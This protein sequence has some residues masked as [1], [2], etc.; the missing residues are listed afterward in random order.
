[1]ETCPRAPE[2]VKELGNH[3]TQFVNVSDEM[4]SMLGLS[5]KMVLVLNR[6]RYFYFSTFHC[7]TFLSG[8]LFQAII[9]L[10]RF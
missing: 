9:D 2:Y 10:H 5:E 8:V 3:G 6:N 4:V 7:Q 1:M